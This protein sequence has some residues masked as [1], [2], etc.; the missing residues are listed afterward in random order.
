LESTNNR[1]EVELERAETL[2][3]VGAERYAAG[4]LAG[5]AQASVRFTSAPIVSP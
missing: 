5:A 4:N 1:A 2:T 3:G